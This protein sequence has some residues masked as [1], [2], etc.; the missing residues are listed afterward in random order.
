[1]GIV[2]KSAGGPFRATWIICCSSLILYKGDG[3]PVMTAGTSSG[4]MESPVKVL[5]DHLGLLDHLME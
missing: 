5:K 3:E 4:I 2:Y 1:M